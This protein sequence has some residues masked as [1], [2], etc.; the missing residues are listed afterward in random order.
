M[1]PLPQII[2]RWPVGPERDDRL[3]PHGVPRS[4]PAAVG[5]RTDTITLSE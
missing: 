2:S 3:A 5:R 4:V 1:G